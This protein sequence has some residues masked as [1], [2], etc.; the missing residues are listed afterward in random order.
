MTRGGRV[1][2]YLVPALVLLVQSRADSLYSPIGST[3]YALYTLVTI[4]GSNELK[5]VS[6]GPFGF[7]SVAI[8]T[9]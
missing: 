3:D 1:A 2:R 6:S 7:T 9:D 5:L 4:G 8:V